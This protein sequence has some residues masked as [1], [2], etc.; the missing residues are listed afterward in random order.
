MTSGNGT[1][2]KDQKPADGA[3][4]ASRSRPGLAGSGTAG[5]FV[6]ADLSALGRLC[7]STFGGACA[8]DLVDVDGAT[9]S[10]IRAAGDQRDAELLERVLE[11]L[12]GPQLAGQVQHALRTGRTIY[13][14]IPRSLE[15]ADDGTDSTTPDGS[16]PAWL[17][18]PAV[19]LDAGVRIVLVRSG[20]VYGADDVRDA[21]AI[22]RLATLAAMGVHAREPTP[23]RGGNAADVS[24]ESL[25]AVLH[26]L[27][28]PLSAIAGYADLLLGGGGGALTDS[29]RTYLDRIVDGQRT[30]DR[31]LSRLFDYQ[32]ARLSPASVE[33]A[34]IRPLDLF[35]QTRSLIAPELARKG[36]RCEILTGDPDVHVKADGTRV[37]QIVLNLATN[38]AK[39]TAPGGAMTFSWSHAPR[40]VTLRVSDTGPGIPSDKI[41]AIFEPFVRLDQTS[42]GTGLGLAIARE[43][44]RALGGRIDVTSSPEKGSTFSVTLPRWTVAPSVAVP[45]PTSRAPLGGA[46]AVTRS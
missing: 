34:R 22:A 45:E 38:A 37:G 12:D 6:G 10:L 4:G 35:T 41:E 31:L 3:H 16:P 18:V 1:Q 43:L 7:V 14:S 32:V 33:P 26:D 40:E 36:I 20:R 42:D 29:Q 24:P 8:I 15:D 39:Y 27:R 19:T 17:L 30:L 9:L 28:T 44:A 46:S 5:R 13:R 23:A 21:E 2:R 11:E 25:A